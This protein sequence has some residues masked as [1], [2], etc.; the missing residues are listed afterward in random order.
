V[1]VIAQPI[2]RDDE[3]HLESLAVSFIDAPIPDPDAVR[4]EFVSHPSNIRH[5]YRCT[6]LSG[7]A[8]IDGKSEPRTVALEND[9]WYWLLKPV[10][11]PHA[12]VF[13]VPLRRTVEI[14]DGQS[15][16]ILLEWIGGFEFS[17]AGH[18]VLF[19]ILPGVPA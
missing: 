19:F 12:K 10:D 14:G 6:V 4:V 9:S 17:C 11:F 13:G 2:R 16:D 1:K 3:K 7:I 18:L 5:Q 8:A 15:Q